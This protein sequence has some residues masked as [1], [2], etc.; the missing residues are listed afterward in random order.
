LKLTAAL[1]GATGAVGQRYVAMLAKH[2]FIELRVLMGH[3]SAG[4]RY[5]EA[6]RW[7]LP[8]SIPEPFAS[9]QV[10]RTDPREAK[11]CD[12]VFSALP[13]DV[14]LRVEKEFAS[15]GYFVISEA[16]AHRMEGD[17]PLVVPE[18]NPEHLELLEVQ[19]RARGWRGSIVATPNC[20]VTGLVMALK[21]LDD[22]FQLRDVIVTT[23]Q[24]LSGAGY[25]GVA[26]LDIVDNVIPYIKDEEEKIEKET[27]KILGRVSNHTIQERDLGVAASCNRVA[28]LDG[29]MESVYVRVGREVQE[30][31]AVRALEGFRG[32]PQRLGLTSAP[33]RPIIVRREED[34]PQPRLDR[35]SGSVPGMSVVVGRVRRGLE[36]NSLRFTLLVH[37]T[38]RGAAGTA[39]LVAELAERLGYLGG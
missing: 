25:P 35:L 5:S 1:L 7:L 20:T 2:P 15:A 21:P 11:G 6:V 3:G 34:R 14:A 19:R 24:A 36:P 38:V 32:L 39:I 29:H 28:V 12:L 33:E 13:S 37:N 31:E 22:G 27:R 26:S 9:M 16:S 23:M 10:S 30:V 8:E 17:V 18:V 4:K